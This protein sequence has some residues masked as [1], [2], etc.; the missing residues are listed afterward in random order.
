MSV[1]LGDGNRYGLIS[2]DG[3]G[4]STFVKILGGDLSPPRSAVSVERPTPG[5]AAKDQFA[6][7]NSASLMWCCKVM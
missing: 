1:K 5:Q 4:K 2:A 7:K 3:Y 6:S